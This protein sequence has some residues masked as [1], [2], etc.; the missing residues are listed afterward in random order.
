MEFRLA[1]KQ[2]LTAEMCQAILHDAQDYCR[3]NNIGVVYPWEVLNIFI[4]FSQGKIVDP[5]FWIGVKDGKL[6]GYM[7]TE[8]KMEDKQPC[9]H[10]RQGYIGEEFR[11]NGVAKHCLDIIEQKARDTGFK[12]V[13]LLT[14]KNPSVYGRWIARYGYNRKYTEFKKEV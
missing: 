7:I 9:L 8:A 3:E 2:D 4:N 5:Q 14:E 12:Y 10:I 6:V 1:Q 13:I 11:G